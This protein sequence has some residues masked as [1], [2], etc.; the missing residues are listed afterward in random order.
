VAN[1]SKKM[2]HGVPGPKG[3]QHVGPQDPDEALDED[4]FASEIKGKNSLQGA[5]Q[6]RVHSERHSAA[7]ESTKTEGVVES[8]ER[9]DPKARA[10]RK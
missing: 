2:G 5:D 8:F 1:A 6:A 10:K 3:F 7:G 9:S 4:D